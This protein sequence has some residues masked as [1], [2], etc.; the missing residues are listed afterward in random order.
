MSSYP[1]FTSWSPTVFW[2]KHSPCLTLVVCLVEPTLDNVHIYS[3]GLKWPLPDKS[4]WGLSFLLLDKIKENNKVHAVKCMIGHL[5][6]KL[7]WQKGKARESQLA[8]VAISCLRT[9]HKAVSPVPNTILTKEQRL[10]VQPRSYLHPF[11]AKTAQTVLSGIPHSSCLVSFF[12]L[13]KYGST[14]GFLSAWKIEAFTGCLSLRNAPH[15]VTETFPVQYVSY[16]MK[17]WL[18]KVTCNLMTVILH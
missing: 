17:F 13:R 7:E 12:I 10:R 4:P 18:Y 6:A 8:F 16:H 9:D 14:L 5:I 11:Y 2:R 1:A 15:I 3:L